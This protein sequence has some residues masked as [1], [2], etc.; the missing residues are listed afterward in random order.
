[1]RDDGGSLL[2]RFINGEDLRKEGRR[3]KD[4]PLWINEVSQIAALGLPL[5][6][7]EKLKHF[8]YSQDELLYLKGEDGPEGK[9][10]K[11]VVERISGRRGLFVFGAGHVG[12]SIALMGIMLGF[13]VTLMDDRQEFLGRDRLP[14]CNIHPLKVDFADIEH[15]I[16]L[17]KKSAVV[18]VTRGH[19]CDEVILRQVAN[20][21]VGYVGMIG[22]RRRVEGVFRRLRQEGVSE[23]FLSS[24]KAPIGL[25]IGARSPQEIAV[26]VHAEII[27]HFGCSV[28]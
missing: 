3:F 20:Y 17:S 15:S 23:A 2:I 5:S 14:D 13:E 8:W 1:M 27:K 12:R 9:L 10:I 28:G 6:L 25:D 18:I 26:A 19:Q 22:S 24:V 21:E 7:A 16:L 11:I 4:M